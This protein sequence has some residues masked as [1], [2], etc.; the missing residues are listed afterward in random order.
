MGGNRISNI[1]K[2]LKYF[3]LNQEGRKKE[4]TG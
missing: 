2:K 1:L 3:G 4:E